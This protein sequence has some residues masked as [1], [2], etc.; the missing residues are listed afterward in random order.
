MPAAPQAEPKGEVRVSFADV[1]KELLGATPVIAPVAVPVVDAP[2]TP[3]VESAGSGVEEIIAE[4]ES[5]VAET[6]AAQRLAVDAMPVIAPAAP[7]AARPMAVPSPAPVEVRAPGI[8]S[9]PVVAAAT[10][11]ASM[12]ATAP[13]PTPQPQAAKAP[14][15][16]QAFE[17]LKFPNDGVLTRQWMEFLNQMA[18]TK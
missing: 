17:G 14:E 5:P 4:M 9:A 18:S 10:V 16:P 15:L 11:A 8:A 13:A 6:P 2:Q 7:V 3:A 12:P 1:A